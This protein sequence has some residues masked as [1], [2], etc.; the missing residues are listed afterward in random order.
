MRKYLWLFLIA[1]LL[2]GSVLAQSDRPIRVIV[3]FAAGG[4]YDIIARLV[5]Q[6]ISPA[7]GQPVV[8]D[9]RPGAGGTTGAQ[10]VAKAQPDGDTLLLSG[11]SSTTIA[12][13]LFEKLGY[14]WEK[15]LAPITVIGDTPMVLMA[16]AKF[17]ADN[18]R[19]FLSQARSRPGQLN[20]ASFGLGATSHLIME[21]LMKSAG[22]QLEHIPYKGAAPAL[23]DVVADRVGVVFS[24]VA[25][26]KTYLDDKRVKSFAVASARRSPQLPDVPTLGELGVKDLAVPVWVGMFTTAGTSP[27]RIA[28]IDQEIRKAI[29][30]DE[31]KARLVSLGVD[32]MSEGPQQFAALLKEDHQ[33]WK[34]LIGGGNI[35]LK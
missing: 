5:G 14:D 15:E 4:A 17:P 32:I 20:Y 16:G 27:A 30:A 2:P 18:F 34:Q 19:D 13:F 11:Q 1:L 12:P 7:L 22:I 10:M 29:A 31:V 33:R 3:P 35:K 28:R 23:V 26:A 9:N 8:V 24:S 21:L 6:K 25:S